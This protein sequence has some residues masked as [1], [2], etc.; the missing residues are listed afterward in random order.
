MNHIADV[1]EIYTG[2]WRAVC[3]CGE[4]EYQARNKAEIQRIFDAHKAQP[5]DAPDYRGLV[6][7]YFE[8][9]ACCIGEHSTN[10]KEEM[11]WLLEKCNS[12][13]AQEGY[14]LFTA[15]EMEDWE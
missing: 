12:W 14:P 9:E 4:W 5:F 10:S 7:R 8:S 3:R 1:T 6:L 15:E 2:L 13:L 11:A